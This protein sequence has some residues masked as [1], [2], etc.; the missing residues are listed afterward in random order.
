VELVVNGKKERMLIKTDNL[1]YVDV[2]KD[3]NPEENSGVFVKAKFGD[4]EIVIEPGKLKKRFEAIVKKYKLMEGDRADE[5]ADFLTSGDTRSVSAEEFGK[6]YDMEVD[7]AG[8]FLAWINVGIGFKEE[9][10]DP[11]AK[12]AAAMGMGTGKN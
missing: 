6:K 4:Q 3:D 7:D 8:V 11:N 1:E 9:A 2:F 5:I 12:E 10:I